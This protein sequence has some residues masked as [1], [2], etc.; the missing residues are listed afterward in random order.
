LTLFD[1]EKTSPYK[2]Q[3]D[4]ARWATFNFKE[5]L[6]NSIIPSIMDSSQIPLFILL[7]RNKHLLLQ[8]PEPIEVFLR[9]VDSLEEQTAGEEVFKLFTKSGI[10]FLNAPT[11]LSTGEQFVSKNEMDYVIRDHVFPMALYNKTLFGFMNEDLKTKAIACRRGLVGAL[12]DKSD[13]AAVNDE[14]VTLTNGV[15]YKLII[16]E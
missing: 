4:F 16:V 8:E 13:V 14:S 7:I 9:K 3:A 6:V 11:L 12:S 5:E 2:I 10:H 1:L 15:V